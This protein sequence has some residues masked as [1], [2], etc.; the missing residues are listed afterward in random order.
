M[1]ALRMQP[2]TLAAALLAIGLGFAASEL[3]SK[4]L[5]LGIAVPCVLLLLARP[6]W[7]FWLLIASIPVTVDFD[8]GSP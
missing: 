8:P 2:G 7:S 1:T 5:M 6:R 4:A 3:G